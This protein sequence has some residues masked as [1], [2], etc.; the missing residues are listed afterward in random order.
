MKANCILQTGSTTAYDLLISTP[1][2]EW[3]KC[4]ANKEIIVTGY[5]GYIKCPA[6]WQTMCK[7][8][9]TTSRALD[10]AATVTPSPLALLIFSILAVIYPLSS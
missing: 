7:T 1:A 3:V 6:E 9:A 5:S 8:E 2:G 10:G 4:E